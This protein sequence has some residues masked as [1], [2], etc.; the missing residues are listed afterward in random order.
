MNRSYRTPIYRRLRGYA[1]DPSLSTRLD[2]AVVNEAIYKIKWEYVDQGP[3]GEYLEIVDYDPASDCFYEPVNLDEPFILAQDGLSPS[4][5]NPQFHQQMVYAVSMLTINNFER[6]LGRP[7]LW[8]EVRGVER[9]FLKRLR[10]YPHALREPNA[11]YSPRKKALLFGYFPA[12]IDRPG[13]FLPGG[14]VFTCLSHDIVAHETTHALLDG[15]YSLFNEPTNPDSLAFHEAFADIVAL[16]QHFSFPEVLRHQ[17]S[18]TRGDLASQNLLGELAQQFG[19]AVG[20]YGALRDAIGEYDP[21]NETWRPSEPDALDYETI[22]EPHARGAILVAAVFEAFLSIYRSRIADLVR[23]GSSGTGILEGALHPDLVNRLAREAAKSAQ[24][25]LHMCIRALDYC[26]PIEMTF[27]D[28]LRAIITADFDL[29]Q[30]DDRGY[31]IA[32]IEAFRRRGIYPRSVRTLSVESLRW[33]LIGETE[34]FSRPQ[35]FSRHLTEFANKAIYAKDREWLFITTERAKNELHY[36]IAE[37]RED[38]LKML[39]HITGVQFESGLDGLEEWEAGRPT[40]AVHNLR[41]IRR[42]APDGTSL[43][44]LMFSIIQS[45]VVPFDPNVKESEMFPFK[46]GCTLIFD[47]LEGGMTLR[48]VIRKDIADETR[49]EL[50]RRYH[51]SLTADNS[52]RAM[53]FKQTRG[54]EEPFAML[55]RGLEDGFLD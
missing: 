34:G 3:I 51:R 27:G 50:R 25:V 55:H 14:V 15:M 54:V 47:L 13:R 52:L 23:I 24:H 18:H 41:T 45:R 8:G 53:Y 6:A 16:F 46:G 39:S 21:Q 10:I 35:P 20:N 36:L 43:N 11:F 38:N 28:Y 12:P 48:Y 42:L 29:I 5:G 7:A 2:T 33:P 49:L 30:E 37:T 1:F 31:R 19:E 17:I 32:F 44:Q 4:E 26:P 9:Y 22:T 40:F